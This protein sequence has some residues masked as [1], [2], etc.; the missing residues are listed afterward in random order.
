VSYFARQILETLA[1]P[2]VAA[3]LLAL[4][5]GILWMRGRRAPAGALLAVA[6]VLV[7]VLS[8]AAVG[9]ALLRPLERRYHS[10]EGAASL[11]AVRYV[12]VLG[13]SYSPRSDVSP[14]A[15]LDCEGLARIVEG[16]RVLRRLPGARLIVS[17]GAPSGREP[18]AHGYAQLAEDLGIDEASLIVLDHSLNTDAEARAIAAAIGSEPFLLVTSAWHMPR[19]MRLM[20][21]VHARPIALPTGQQTG[22]PCA[23]YW[24][25][26]LPSS[27]GLRRSERALHEYL[28]IAALDLHLE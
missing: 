20:D 3:V 5:A 10:I 28:G 12:V 17:G 26:F 25:C 13:S 27:T 9:D 14:V 1:T 11:P 18:S 21:R 24:S 6:G 15:A 4:A 2:L 22:T 16:V 23:S 7:Y 8:L 19:A